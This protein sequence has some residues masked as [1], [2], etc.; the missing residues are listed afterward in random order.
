MDLNKT[1]ANSDCPT[2]FS[3]KSCNSSGSISKF[4]GINDYDDYDF[5]YEYEYDADPGYIP[6]EQLIPVSIVYGVTLVLGLLGNSLVIVS[7]AK[8]KNMQNVTNMFL[9]SLATADLLLVMICVPVKVCNCCCYFIL[10]RIWN[11]NFVQTIKR[12]HKC[13]RAINMPF[14]TEKFSTPWH[15]FI[16]LQSKCIWNKTYHQQ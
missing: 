11:R 16:L 7:V 12:K 9:L 14:G 1:F 2:M 15:N 8:F 5:Y 3:N 13:L 6:I 10:F 4:P